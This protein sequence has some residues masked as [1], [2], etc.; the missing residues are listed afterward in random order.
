MTS[1]LA[2]LEAAIWVKIN[3]NDKTMIG[4]QKQ[5]ENMEIKE[6]L[7]KSQPKKMTENHRSFTNAIHSLQSELMPKEAVTFT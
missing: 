7:Y 2:V 3:A 1:S 5:R 4:N 6:I